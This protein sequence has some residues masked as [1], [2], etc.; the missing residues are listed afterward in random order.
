M[1]GGQHW[2]LKKELEAL[3]WLYG[4]EKLARTGRKYD[5]F[6]LGGEPT[7]H[8]GIPDIVKGLPPGWRWAIQTDAMKLPWTPQQARRNIGFAVE[9]NFDRATPREPTYAE[10]LLENVVKLM[11]WGFRPT[12]HATLL[13]RHLDFAAVLIPQLRR[14]TTV[15]VKPAVLVEGLDWDLEKDA[16]R[17]LI[18]IAGK[19][20]IPTGTKW[21]QFR[22]F[23]FCTA[24]SE[25][26]FTVLPDGKVLRCYSSLWWPKDSPAEPLGDLLSFSPHALS[27]PCSGPH[28]CYFDSGWARRE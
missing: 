25:N 6:F 13:P 10:T 4:F 8:P 9:V 14:L 16:G 17:R 18:H 21:S 1:A 7:L 26:Y 20:L 3:Q 24:G 19:H 27:L 28:I 22:R 5:V 12:L 2:K 11:K 15:W 23:K